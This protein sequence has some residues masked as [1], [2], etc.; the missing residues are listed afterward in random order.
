M[1]DRLKTFLAA[2]LLFV[3]MMYISKCQAQEV[4]KVRY[5]QI[6]QYCEQSCKPAEGVISVAP[7]YVTFQIKGDRFFKYEIC[8]TDTIQSGY[9]YKLEPKE[10]F[11]HAVFVL[12]N[13]QGLKGMLYI[14]FDNQPDYSVIFSLKEY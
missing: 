2:A 11:N 4:Y 8:Q 12:Y 10:D 9:F 3:T 1:T 13:K 5:F 14:N 6:T 7:S